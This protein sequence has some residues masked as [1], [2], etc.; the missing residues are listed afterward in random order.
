ATLTA[1]KWSF[2][3]SREELSHA[4]M[5]AT[6]TITEPAKQFRFFG[7]SWSAWPDPTFGDG[8][9]EAALVLRGG[10]ESGYR[11]QISHQYQLVALVK[12][13]DGGYVRVVPF[14][15]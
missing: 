3:H 11:L 10:K 8:G 14:A 2:L 9:F 7:E 13:P 4:E 1:D 15:V 12:Y 5:S 6:V